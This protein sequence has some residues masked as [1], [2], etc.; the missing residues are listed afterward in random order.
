MRPSTKS[1]LARSMPDSEERTVIVA[2]HPTEIQLW[3]QTPYPGGSREELSRDHGCRLEARGA[4][5]S[6]IGAGSAMAVMARRELVQHGARSVVVVTDGTTTGQSAERLPKSKP[7]VGPV[8]SIS[9]GE[10]RPNPLANQRSTLTPWCLRRSFQDR[11][12]KF[13]LI[14][15][16]I[17]T[18][19]L[20]KR[21]H[22]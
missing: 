22:L 4:S 10:A 1:V 15:M 12:V 20:H 13:F 11:K 17:K 3:P 8:Q 16:Q 6:V 18:R 2:H 19:S 14:R 21:V 9:R 5:N 7:V